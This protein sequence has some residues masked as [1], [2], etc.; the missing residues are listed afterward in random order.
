M[1]KMNKKFSSEYHVAVTRIQEMEE[2]LGKL[3]EENLKLR[4]KRQKTV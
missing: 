3:K 1:K 2:D 4:C